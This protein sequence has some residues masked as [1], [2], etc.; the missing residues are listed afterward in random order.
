MKTLEQIEFEQDMEEF[1]EMYE[2]AI[3][4]EK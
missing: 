2:K 1:V 3:K 4:R